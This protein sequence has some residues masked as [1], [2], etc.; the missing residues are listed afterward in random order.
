[1]FADRMPNSARAAIVFSIGKPTTFEKE[2]S[3]FAMVSAPAILRGISAGFI[4]RIHFREV[5]FDGCAAQAA[6]T[7]TRDLVKSCRSRGREMTNENCRTNFVSSSAQAPQNLRSL[8]EIR[9]FTDDFVIERDE[10]VGCEHDLIR[11]CLCDR[12][13]PF[14]WRST[15]SARAT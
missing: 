4:E 2:P 11:I 14:G 13:L 5:I 8:L 1:M 3:I 9:R 10:R 12:T 7:N 6:K 15:S